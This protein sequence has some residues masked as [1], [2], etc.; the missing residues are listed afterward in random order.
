ML[1]LERRRSGEFSDDDYVDL[2]RE[3]DTAA[4]G[5]GG[6][7]GAA[8]GAPPPTPVGEAGGAPSTSF[9]STEMA[10]KPERAPTGVP[11][12]LE[13]GVAG[14]SRVA[15]EQRVEKEVDRREALAHGRRHLVTP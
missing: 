8:A 15:R 5:A 12:W 2:A 13:P 11:C 9:V 6:A 3:L 1:D 4:G 7:A 14:D 10:P